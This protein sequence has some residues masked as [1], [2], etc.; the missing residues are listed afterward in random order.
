MSA[1][2]GRTPNGQRV[3]TGDFSEVPLSGSARIIIAS[4]RAADGTYED[5]TGPVLVDWLRGRG[6]DV[7]EQAVVP[8]GPAVGHA[9]QRAL[10]EGAD[11]ILTSGG[12]GITPDDVT[13]EQTRPFLDYE[14][15]GIP[16]EIR[17]IGA[18]KHPASLISR[19]LAGMAGAALVVNLPGS[20]GGVKDGIS[21][22][23]PIL[24]HLLEQRH[25]KGH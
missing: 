11:V 21:V 13:P 17:R 25:G 2:V 6:M 23:D 12:T 18:A 15:L 7:P 1:P 10:E 14:L 3:N 8:D 22:L 4:T 19:G 5:R 16:E 24:G 20:R 9:I